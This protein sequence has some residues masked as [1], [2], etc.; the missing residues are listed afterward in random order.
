MVER[1]V[2]AM[3]CAGS[4]VFFWH[5]AD[6]TRLSSNVRFWGT[7]SNDAITVTVWTG[8]GFHVCLPVEVSI[9]VEAR[10]NHRT[11]CSTLTTLNRGSRSIWMFKIKPFGQVATAR[12]SA[13]VF[14]VTGMPC[15]TSTLMSSR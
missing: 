2:A 8:F 13:T 4:N 15:S 7:L 5:K 3:N 9:R 6:I 11:A 1:A 12:S 10:R 14:A